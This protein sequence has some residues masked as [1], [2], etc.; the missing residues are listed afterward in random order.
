MNLEN[1]HIEI[2]MESFCRNDRG[3]IKKGGIS[4]CTIR[5]VPGGWV[6]EAMVRTFP[7]AAAPTPASEKA[8]GCTSSW[9]G[10][11]SCER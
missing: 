2:D 11:Q 6:L 5:E 1:H 3:G 4:G 9:C 10:G 7:L 8:A